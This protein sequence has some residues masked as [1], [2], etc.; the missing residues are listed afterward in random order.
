MCYPNP[1]CF[2]QYCLSS[3]GSG[4]EDQLKQDQGPSHLG[5]YELCSWGPLLWQP[6]EQGRGDTMK[7]LGVHFTSEPGMAAQ[8]ADIRGK[9]TSRIWA[10]RHLGRM[11]M[12]RPDLL[13]VYKSTILPMHDY[14]STVYNSSLTLTQPGQLERP[15]AMA[16]PFI[17]L[18][19]LLSTHGTQSVGE[20]NQ[21]R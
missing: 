18:S 14:C 20:I 9:F 7:I 5:P 8:V 19:S 3:H 16:R 10:L 17:L 6:R 15:Q 13:R 12:T 4:N 1:E 21:T 11:G 2:L